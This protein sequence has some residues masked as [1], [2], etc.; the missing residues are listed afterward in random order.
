MLGWSQMTIDSGWTVQTANDSAPP[1]SAIGHYAAFDANSGF[2]HLEPWMVSD[3]MDG[4]PKAQWELAASI[5]HEVIHQL[6]PGGPFT[7]RPQT[8]SAVW[9]PGSYYYRGKTLWYD[10]TTEYPFNLLNHPIGG[11]PPSNQTCMLAYP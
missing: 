4:D 6:A 1:D 11:T 9:L 3:A 7:H 2:I 8:N 10:P 5:M